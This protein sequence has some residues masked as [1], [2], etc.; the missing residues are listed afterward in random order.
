MKAISEIL[1]RVYL[2][3]VSIVTIFILLAYS[4]MLLDRGLRTYVFPSANMPAYLTNCEY[5]MPVKEVTPDGVSVPYTEEERAERCAKIQERE[6]ENYQSTQA[7]RSVTALSYV[8]IS[9]PI[10]LVHFIVFYRDWKK[11]KN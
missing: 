2:A 10:F 3:L 6:I 5:D 1:F 8:L 11:S 7:G 4:G 9:F